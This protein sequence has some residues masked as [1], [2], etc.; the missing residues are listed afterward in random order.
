MAFFDP[1]RFFRQ[2]LSRLPSNFI[3]V[4]EAALAAPRQFTSTDH[5]SIEAVAAYVDGE[6]PMK[7]H[8]R[9]GSHLSQ[10]RQCAAEVEAQ[11]GRP[12]ALR[13]SRLVSIPHTLMGLLSQILS[14]RRRNRPLHRC[15]PA[16]VARQSGVRELSVRESAARR[17]AAWAVAS[18]GRVKSGIPGSG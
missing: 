10:C 7:A 17:H 3:S 14:P 13:E 11:R 5:L 1:G 12:A 8:L 18:A 6:L 9:A 4:D 16:T 15:S 2:A